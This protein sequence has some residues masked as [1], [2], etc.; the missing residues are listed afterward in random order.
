MKKEIYE[1]ILQSLIKINLIANKSSAAI[2]MLTELT[3]KY[4]IRS[5]FDSLCLLVLGDHKISLTTIAH[6]YCQEH[7]SYIRENSI[8]IEKKSI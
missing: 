3:I 7:A 8:K 2:C 1:I 5:E 6:I 4:P